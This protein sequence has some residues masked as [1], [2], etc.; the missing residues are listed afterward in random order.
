M[1]AD[2]TFLKA[3]GLGAALVLTIPILAAISGPFGQSE[4]APRQVEPPPYTLTLSPDQSRIDLQGR[5]DFG[6]TRDLT[7]L[8]EVEPGVR[9]LR[10][11]S[12]G[13]RVA[14]ARGLVKLVERF[15]LATRAQG[16]CASAC[17]L[18]FIAGL[19]RG[20][21]PGARL[22]FH[23]YDLRS[24]VFGLIDPEAEM[25]RDSAVFRKAG[26]DDAFMERAR[27][28]PH[29]EMWFPTRHDLIGAGVIDPG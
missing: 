27:A 14:E 17:T 4:T 7:A 23:G 1:A 11:Q 15:A 22:G 18:V 24:P 26:V 9:T 3:I 29:R 13:G 19:S 28:V 2:E 10:L 21:D 6:V 12:P 5:I 20:L 25:A 16:D 8:L